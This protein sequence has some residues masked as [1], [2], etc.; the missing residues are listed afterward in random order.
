M[1]KFIFGFLLWLGFIPYEVRRNYR[2]IEVHKQKPDYLNSFG[3]RAFAAAVCL[4]LMSGNYDPVMD[5]KHSLPIVIYEVTSFYLVFDPWLNL[6]RGKAW[7]Y[8][9]AQSG[10]L[11][12][13]G[14]PYYYFLKVLC[15]VLLVISIIVIWH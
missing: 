6:R 10:W 5:W 8:Q 4:A 3:F 14:K 11:D 1:T 9:G 15:A 12:K 2:I 7:D 13:L